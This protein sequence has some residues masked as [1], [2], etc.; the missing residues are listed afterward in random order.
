[1]G[2]GLGLGGWQGGGGWGL[3]QLWVRARSLNGVSCYNNNNNDDNNNN[4]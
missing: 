3:P 4:Q 2:L 1:M